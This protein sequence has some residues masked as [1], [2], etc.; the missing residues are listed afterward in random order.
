MALAAQYGFSGVFGSVV[1]SLGAVLLGTPIGIFADTYLAEYARY[2]KFSF[3]ARFVNNILLSAP[4]IVLGLFIYT[5]WPMPPIME[6]PAW[7]TWMRRC[8]DSAE[9]LNFSKAG[10]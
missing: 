6:L 9:E 10:R 7:P 1:M 2:G 8:Q 5:S 4:S 3:V